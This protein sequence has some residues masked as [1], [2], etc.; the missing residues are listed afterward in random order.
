MNIFS[1]STQRQVS[2]VLKSIIKAAGLPTRRLPLKL[3]IALAIFLTGYFL[4]GS[5]FG[6]FAAILFI[7]ISFNC[8][9]RLPL[10]LA[11]LSLAASSFL[12]VF[13]KKSWGEQVAFWSFYFLAIALFIMAIT[14]LRG[15][16]ENQV[17][18]DDS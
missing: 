18:E 16:G 6:F 8:D 12:L 3:G 1:I 9:Y 11:F 13:G 7:S 4:I 14:S 15:P 5:S 10:V 17:I 2:R